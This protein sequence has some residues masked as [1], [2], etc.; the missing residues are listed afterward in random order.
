MVGVVG[1]NPI[2]PTKH[3][4][5][6]KL[7]CLIPFFFTLRTHQSAT[8]VNKRIPKSYK[9]RSHRMPC[10]AVTLHADWSR[11]YWRL[12]LECGEYSP[13]L[14]ETPYNQSERLFGTRFAGHL[15]GEIDK[16]KTS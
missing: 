4:N 1:S 5:G 12:P 9:I 7:T 16:G 8:K 6:I 13:D 14:T 15:I 2:A 11:N 10:V 3:L